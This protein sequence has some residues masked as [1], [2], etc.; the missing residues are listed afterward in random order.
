[1][2][3]NVATL[4]F[5]YDSCELSFVKKIV[6]LL[7]EVFINLIAPRITLSQLKI[8]FVRISR[9]TCP[10]QM[11]LTLIIDLLS[12]DSLVKLDASK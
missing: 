5:I 9:R 11:L 7:N 2:L 10:V 4:H 1:M 8:F 12:H 6:A 3:S